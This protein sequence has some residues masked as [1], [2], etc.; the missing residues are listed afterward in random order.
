MTMVQI[1]YILS[2]VIL[3]KRFS[4]EL[5]P[6]TRPVARGVIPQTKMST[7]AFNISIF[8]KTGGD[9]GSV[10]NRGGD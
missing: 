2:K 7:E 8:R 9:K 4:K 3:L 1:K 6:I 5:V 10:Q